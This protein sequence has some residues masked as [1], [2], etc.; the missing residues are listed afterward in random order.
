GSEKAFKCGDCGKSFSWNSHL[1]RHRR[2]HTGEKP[3]ACPE[4]FREGS[5]LA[6]HPRLRSGEKPHACPECGKG[7]GVRSNLAKHRRTHL[8]EK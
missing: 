2:I 8:G 7:F 4:R 1:E 5:A 3:F 6:G